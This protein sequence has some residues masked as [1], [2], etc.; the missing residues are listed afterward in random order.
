MGD[1]G[2]TLRSLE[3]RVE[4]TTGVE[5]TEAS[6]KLAQ[7]EAEVHQLEKVLDGVGL[8]AL[9]KL[10]KLS[11]REPMTE[12]AMR[13]E[14]KALLKGSEALLGVIDARFTELNA[15]KQPE[16]EA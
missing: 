7:I 14:R 1:L 8:S 4:E 11:G 6:S 10:E 15:R 2:G 3:K 13:V 12:E 9:V 16:T 5:V